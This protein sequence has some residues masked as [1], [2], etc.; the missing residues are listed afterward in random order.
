MQTV[1][2][3]L[4]VVTLLGWLEFVVDAARGR[5]HLAFLQRVP[6]LSES[7]GMLP[8]VSVVLAARNEE[9]GVASAVRSMLA[10]EYPELEVIAID[11]RSEDSTGALLDEL[12]AVHPRLRVLHIDE[13]PAG[14]L[15]KNL[16]LHRGAQAARG[17]LLL[18]T[19][20]D[21]V[22]EPSVLGRA[23]RWMREHRVDHLA[24]ATDVHARTAWVALFVATFALFFNSYFRPWRAAGSNPRWY[25]GFGGFNL[26]RRELYDR[27]GAHAALAMD[28]IDDVNLGRNLKL[29]GARQAC[30]VVGPMVHVEWYPNLPAA[31][32]GLE[33]NTL[34]AVNWS[35]ALLIVGALAQ[36][37]MVAWP[38]LAVLLTDGAVLWLNAAV[39]LLIVSSHAALLADTSLPRWTSLA[40][41]IGVLLVVYTYLRAAWLTYRRGGIEWRGTFYSLA[42]LR[43]AERPERD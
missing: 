8:R 14:W 11:D 33:K 42:E 37:L 22:F 41:P 31:I 17:E 25:I 1:L 21:V 19:D 43:R 18:F 28:P 23:I 27:A 13:L 3:A 4:G 30:A 26:V 6:P 40:L 34:A 29:A 5:R 12:A 38:F 32:R 16:A 9:L 24:G 36:I 7:P 20:A 35:L 2:L 15:G 39:L 10:L